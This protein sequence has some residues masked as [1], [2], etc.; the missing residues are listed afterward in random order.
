MET[1][2]KID[3][4]ILFVDM[5]DEEWYK[6]FK[7]IIENYNIPNRDVNNERRFRDYGTLRGVFRSIDMYA[8]WINNVFLVVQSET[9]IPKWVNEKGINIVLHEDFIPKE[10]LPTYNCNT[11]ETHL[12]LIPGLSEK[13]IYFNDDMLLSDINYP[14]EYFIGDKCVHY[15]RKIESN[16]LLHKKNQ[17]FYQRL[18][19]NNSLA[20]YNF[21]KDIDL[22]IVYYNS[23][24]PTPML[25]SLC[26]EIY[27][28]INIDEYITLFREPYNLTQELFTIYAL[29]KRRLILLPNSNN[30][31]YTTRVDKYDNFTPD[32][33]DNLKKI[34]YNENIYNS[35]CV[36]DVF[37]NTNLNDNEIIL[38]VA[39]KIINE[40]WNTPSIRFEK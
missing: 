2:D 21:I 36:N 20:I 30:M 32:M 31:T 23:H 35:I 37:E 12:H 25:K 6:G 14:E 28:L 8:P 24:G 16:M 40:R 5:S 29:Y 3:A 15:M 10:Y 19:F 39:K 34:V 26:H 13:F 17:D 33:M 38:N 9:Q 11:I 7:K 22:D 1:K 27:E 4:V 18:R